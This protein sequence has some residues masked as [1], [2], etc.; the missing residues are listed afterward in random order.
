VNLKP[1]SKVVHIFKQES[2]GA[3]KEEKRRVK[4]HCVVPLTWMTE[5]SSASISGAHNEEKKLKVSRCPVPLTWMPRLVPKL[6]TRKS[7]KSL[8]VLFL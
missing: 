3:H 1:N 8:V 2:Y 4:S 5:K 6:I 7:E